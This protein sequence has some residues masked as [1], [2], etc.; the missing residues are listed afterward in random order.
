MPEV[1]LSD[2]RRYAI[3]NRI[4]ITY[5]DQSGRKARVNRKGIVEIPGITGAPPYNVEEVLAAAQEFVLEP[6]DPKAQVRRL[7][8]QQIV[9]LLGSSAPAPAP[10]EE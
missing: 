2:L 4:P 5:L 10:K 9:E 6:E 3:L 7:S 8:R 1:K